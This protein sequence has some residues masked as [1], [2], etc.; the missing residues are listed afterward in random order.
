MNDINLFFLF[1]TLSVMVIIIYRKVY[2]NYKNL[3]FDLL[4]LIYVYFIAVYTYINGYSILLNII[5][6]PLIIYYFNYN[7]KLIHSD[8][9]NLIH[10][11]SIISA[12]ESLPYGILLHD[13]NNHIYLINNMMIDL[14][15][16]IQNDIFSNIDNLWEKIINHPSQINFKTIKL[17]EYP[18]VKVKDR[19]Y[20]FIKINPTYKDQTYTEMYALDTTLLYETTLDII[21][22]T[23]NLK[24]Q[25]KQLNNLLNNLF[26]I[27]KQE[28]VLDYKIKVHNNMGEIILSSRLS[29]KNKN[30]I[31]NELNKWEDLLNNLSNSFSDQVNKSTKQSLDD[32]IKAGNELGT[33]LIISGEFPHDKP[34]ADTL[35]ETLRE[36]MINAKKHANA[37]KVFVTITNYNKNIEVLIYDNGKNI[38]NDLNIKGG[39]SQIVSD[40]KNNWGSIDFYPQENF[41]ILIKF[42]Y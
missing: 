25:Q 24:Y 38:T 9:Y 28:E 8:N 18:L 32:L 12:I 7:H 34:Y 42:P 33:Q 35:Y 31:K 41:S 19:I 40:V 27:F 5:A 30:N 23:E 11:K 13:Q 20:R 2:L 29:L 16:S 10:K 1:F 37:T 15:S 4:L 26:E 6:Y 3:I 36:T 17:G 21:N 39:L 14:S 22:Q